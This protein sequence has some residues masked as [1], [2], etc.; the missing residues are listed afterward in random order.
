MDTRP[1]IA[2]ALAAFFVL[3]IVLG[4]ASAQYKFT[5]LGRRPAWPTVAPAP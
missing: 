2:G 4:N 1:V 5:D 3:S